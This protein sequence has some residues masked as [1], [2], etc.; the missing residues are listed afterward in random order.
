MVYIDEPIG[1]RIDRFV[2]RQRLKPTLK[3][4]IELALQEFLDREEAHDK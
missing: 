3:A 2:E 1:E 4:I